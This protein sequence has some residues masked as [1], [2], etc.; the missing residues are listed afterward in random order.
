MQVAS[1]DDY[2]IVAAKKQTENFLENYPVCSP[3]TSDNIFK[4]IDGEPVCL[5]KYLDEALKAYT[6][7]A[8]SDV[9]G[10]GCISPQ[11]SKQTGSGSSRG[12][13]SFCCTARRDPETEMLQAVAEILAEII[14]VVV[15]HDK[16]SE[17]CL[18]FHV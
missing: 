2:S 5:Y 17:V 4:D 7:R 8:I 9:V 16:G 11:G 1:L 12:L 13:Q 14:E 6:H 15:G 10:S 18:L 3:S